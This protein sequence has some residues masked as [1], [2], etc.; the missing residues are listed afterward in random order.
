MI[1]MHI[2]GTEFYVQYLNYIFAYIIGLKWIKVSKFKRVF[3]FSIHD[4]DSTKITENHS[5]A[6]IVCY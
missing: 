2:S 1:K 6:I 4:T 5:N 3:N